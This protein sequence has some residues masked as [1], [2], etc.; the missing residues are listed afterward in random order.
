[1]N[2]LAIVLGILAVLSGGLLAH[3]RLSLE[4][5]MLLGAGL[6]LLGLLIGLPTGFYY[7]V[8]LYRQ[9]KDRMQLPER[10]WVRP[11]KLHSHLKKE[12]LELLRPWF[13]TGGIG[14]L[15]ICAGCAAL[16]LSAIR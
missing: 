8:L 4:V 2:E 11:Q 1:M 5:L 12:E 16:F 13:V 15:I 3:A 14:F 9:L 10:W 6:V 7:H